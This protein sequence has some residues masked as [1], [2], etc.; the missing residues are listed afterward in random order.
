MRW[1]ELI[2]GGH[3]V[4]TASAC[5]SENAASRHSPNARGID[6]KQCAAED[7]AATG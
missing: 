1:D 5:M 6:A 3:V 2:G 4:V 7:N